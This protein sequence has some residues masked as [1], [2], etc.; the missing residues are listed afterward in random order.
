MG[1][2]VLDPKQKLYDGMVEK[3]L[4]TKTFNDFQDQFSNDVS[5]G[6]LYEGLKGRGL[7]SKSLQEFQDQFGFVKKKDISVPESLPGSETSLPQPPPEGNISQPAANGKV[8]TP[9]N[10]TPEQDAQFAKVMAENQK[11][12]EQKRFEQSMQQNDEQKAKEYIAEQMGEGPKESNPI[13]TAAKSAWKTLAYDLPSSLVGA[14]ATMADKHESFS[15]PNLYTKEQEESIKRTKQGL[16]DWSIKHGEKGEELSKDLVSN[17]QKVKDPIDALNWLSFALGQASAQI[18]VSIATAGT[19]SIG[20]EVGSI[21]LD[22]IKKIAADNNLTIKQVIDQKLDHPAASV[23]YG[24]AAGLLD[25]VGAKNVTK[26]FPKNQLLKSLRNRASMMAKAG[27]IEGGTEYS[28]TWMEQIGAGQTA[29]NDLGK[30]W[31]DANTNEKSRERL[32]AMAQGAVG[33]LGAHSVTNNSP[34]QNLKYPKTDLGNVKQQNDALSVRSA[35]PV[36][37]DEA[38]TD[39]G[40]VESRIPRTGTKEPSNAQGG[41]TVS[42]VQSEVPV[43]QEEKVVPKEEPNPPE[44]PQNANEGFQSAGEQSKT[45]QSPKALG[46]W[47]VEN[48]QTGDKV[49]VSDDEYYEVERKKTKKG[50]VEIELHHFVKNDETGEFENNPSGIKILSDKNKGTKLEGL[51]TKGASDLFEHSYTDNEGNRKVQRSEYVTAMSPTSMSETSTETKQN[52]TPETEQPQPGQPTVPENTK[53]KTPQAQQAEKLPTVEAGVK[54]PKRSKSPK[55]D[56]SI[57][58]PEDNVQLP[59][60]TEAGIG[61]T[62]QGTGEQNQQGAGGEEPSGSDSVNREENVRQSEVPEPSQSGTEEN[63]VGEKIGKKVTFEWLGG[64]REGEIVSESHD[65]YKIK[66]G[67]TVYPVHKSS[68]IQTETKTETAEPSPK[69]T[70]NETTNVREEDKVNFEWKNSTKQGVVVSREGSKVKIKSGKK[71]YTVDRSKLQHQAPETAS[72]VVAYN[73]RKKNPIGVVSNGLSHNF[74]FDTDLGDK[75][76][77]F[78]KEQF[79]SKGYLP[80][81]VFDRWNKTRAEISAYE[82]QIKFTISDLKKAIEKDYGKITDAQVTDLNAVLSGKKPLNPIPQ[83]TLE[84]IQDMRAQVDNLSKRFI[85]EGIVSGD[86]SAKFTDNLGTYLTRSYRKYD[87]PFWSVPEEVKNK[88]MA[89]L[90]QKYANYSQEEMQGLVNYLL[91][92]PDAPMAIMKGSKLG[93]K[94]LSILKKRGEIAP[95]IRA[96]M[97]EYGDP[98]LNYARSVTKMANLI[99]KNHFLQDVRKD[100]MEKF[101]F[102]KPQGQFY[103]PIA[104]EG[105][106]TMAPLNGLYTTPEIAQAFAEFNA[107]EANSKFI[108]YLLKFFGYIKAGKTIFSIQTHARNFFGN[109]GFVIA[110]GH[111]RLDKFG[112]AAQTAFANLYSND[113]AMREKLQEYIKLGIVQDSASAGELRKIIGDIKEGNDFFERLNEGRLQK[114]KNGVLSTAQNLY[115]F[116]D[117][118]YKIYA[119]EN[120][121]SRYKKAFPNWNKQQVKDK[122]AEIVRSTYPT[123]SL[124]PKIVKEL[125]FNPFIGSFVA[126]PAEV[127]RTAYNTAALAKSELSSKETASIGAQRMAGLM[128]AVSLPLGASI[129][130]RAFL[131]MDDDDDKALRKFVAPWQETSEFLYL[132]HQADKITLLDMGYSDPFSYLK[133]PFYAFMN[134]NSIPESA[135]DMSWQILQPFLSEEMVLTAYQDVTRNQKKTGGQIYNPYSTPGEIAMDIFMHVE[136][137]TQVGTVKSVENLAKALKGTTDTYGK[138]Y[139]FGKE[140]T[141]LF[142]GQKTEVKDISQAFRYRVYRLSD[143]IKQTKKEF[144]LVMRNPSSKP[145]DKEHALKRK[146]ET[147]TNIFKDYRA[148]K[149]AAL[150]LGVDIKQ[151]KGEIENEMDNLLEELK[152]E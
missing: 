127:I 20:Q 83:R 93:S 133:R 46:N 59:K 14:M 67:N 138:Q 111:W 36:H 149:L 104:A 68:I 45:D 19:T 148:L 130:S 11:T 129:A 53:E 152:T 114:V 49:K 79:T 23:A 17:L 81:H 65:R 88:A 9:I 54:K 102:D 2:Q 99:A 103:A 101:L 95:E 78:F 15:Q 12:P 47:L 6:K 74:L 75:I 61:S 87:D 51:D 140:L 119:F 122:A 29:G 28:Q 85:D 84:I 123:Y 35:T 128:T 134:G 57:L 38:S 44:K 43:P 86:L 107:N 96:L 141:A 72:D 33:G 92:S 131:G 120:E 69:T 110:N 55:T 62:V 34:E 143:A 89:F 41:Q 32:E 94:D 151:T 24:T 73:R 77:K 137:I 142:T 146:K 70:L 76:K 125:R 56:K 27:A 139:D 48:A 3:G 82:S 60:E 40:K 100:G 66:S 145:E 144:N 25:Y 80:Q 135:F 22:G 50:F 18:P 109:L 30:S 31:N 136:S 16:I 1:K 90:R 105:S 13:V 116:E 8:G 132:G 106:R 4:Y 117:D 58:T 108:Q 64:E 91:Y 52:E 63:G 121:Y 26:V 97:G 147:F 5:I 42:S 7:Y 150:Q 126:F 39:S 112:K 98:L 10:P 37:V 124:V 21:Y 71:T 118:L 115:Q 113:K